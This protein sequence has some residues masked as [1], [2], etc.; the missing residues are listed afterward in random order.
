MIERDAYSNIPMEIVR[1][2]IAVAETGSLS[3]AGE[4]LSLGQPAISS[5]MKRIQ[6]MLGGELFAKTPNGSTPT[7]LGKLA[8]NQARKII[9]AND[10]ML[11]LGGTLNGPQPVRLGISSV[12]VKEFFQHE[13]ATSLRGTAIQTDNSLGITRSL[14]DGYIDVACFLENSETAADVQNLIVNEHAEP[15]IWV[16]AKGFVLSPGAPIP[17]LTWPGDD[18]MIPALRKAGLN[19][20][21]VFNSPDYH[22]KLSALESGIG[23]AALPAR[24][25][26]T[27]LVQAKEYY[28]PPLPTVKALLCAREDLSFDA[29]PLLKRLSNLFFENG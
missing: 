28:L 11:R 17:L 2:I 7:A 15:F 3:K 13:N 14:L 16:R 6:G 26:P 25:M 24:M 8:I 19:Y 9:D 1:M 27:S 29:A 10:Q 23:L 4:R 21:I 22:A 5:Q 12:F 18:I 20:S